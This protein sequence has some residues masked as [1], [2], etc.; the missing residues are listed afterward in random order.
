MRVVKATL[1]V[2]LGAVW[3]KLPVKVQR[4]WVTLRS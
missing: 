1:P 3:L 2:L 4:M